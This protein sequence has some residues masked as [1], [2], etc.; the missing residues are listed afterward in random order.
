MQG[1]PVEQNL[2]HTGEDWNRAE[3]PLQSLVNFKDTSVVFTV[4]YYEE[5]I[6]LIQDVANPVHRVQVTL[7]N[8]KRLSHIHV[9]QTPAGPTTVTPHLATSGTPPPPVTPWP[10]RSTGSD[11]KIFL[12]TVSSNTFCTH[13]VTVDP[14]HPARI[15]S[16]IDEPE[17]GYSAQVLV[18]YGRVFPTEQIGLT[19]PRAIITTAGAINPLRKNIA[20]LSEVVYQVLGFRMFLIGDGLVNYL[21]EKMLMTYGI[22]APFLPITCIGPRLMS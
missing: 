12:E 20:C 19:F 4:L 16:R 9:V 17:G 21:R 11:P 2:I 1:R 15:L 5:K 14:A 8:I 13:P 22:P 6:I 7:S 18:P 10:S 3:F